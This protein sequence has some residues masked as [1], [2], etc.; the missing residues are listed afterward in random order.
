MKL[1]ELAEI[2][3]GLVLA[4]KRPVSDTVAKYSVITVKSITDDGTIDPAEL[5]IFESGEDVR[6]DY[7]TRKGDVVMRLSEPNSAAYIS[8]KDENLLV[9]S[10]CCFVRLKED[11]VLPEF[12]T[13]FLNSDFCRKQTRKFSTGSALGF[14]STQLLKEIDVPALPL[15]RQQKV[16]ELFKLSIVE[17]NLHTELLQL[18]SLYI[19]GLMEELL[20][21]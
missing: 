7:L 19:K 18:K 9:T 5:D 6:S 13:W 12:L 21:Q 3:T 20:Q 11:F 1:G 14:L 16:I 8:E 2:K 4:R 10:Y 15:E 17:R